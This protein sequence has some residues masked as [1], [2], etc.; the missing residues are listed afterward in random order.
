MFESWR[1]RQNV[2]ETFLQHSA[3]KLRFLGY[4]QGLIVVHGQ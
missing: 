2:S 1:D 4:A 3:Y